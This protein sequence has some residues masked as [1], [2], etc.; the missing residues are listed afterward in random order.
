MKMEV[1]TTA[2]T[3]RITMR[4]MID[5]NRITLLF[6][7]DEVSY[8]TNCMNLDLGAPL[9]QLLAQTVNVHLDGVGRD[10]S[11]MSED[12]IFNLLLG[13][14]ASL[15]AHQQFK[16]RCFADRK[17]L[18]LIVYGRLAVSGIKFEIGDAER[19]PKQLAGPS[20]LSF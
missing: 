7:C 20:Q 8:S 10:I 15:A 6:L 13:N 17:D 1:M 14:H 19:A 9:R 12:V 3:C 11:R 5:L 16:H 4:E 18:G 2:T